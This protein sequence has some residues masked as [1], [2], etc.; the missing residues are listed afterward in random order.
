M[1]LR[2]VQ[3]QLSTPWQQN[4]VRRKNYGGTLAVFWHSL[5]AMIW[6]LLDL[7]TPKRTR[8]HA[9][10]TCN[11]AQDEW[12]ALGKWH[13]QLNI[14][15]SISQGRLAG[16]LYCHAAYSTHFK[17]FITYLIDC[18]FSPDEAAQYVMEGRWDKDERLKH[19][20][21]LNWVTKTKWYSSLWHDGDSCS[22]SPGTQLRC[23]GQEP[24]REQR[25]SPQEANSELWRAKSLWKNLS[26]FIHC[27]TKDEADNLGT[28]I[29]HQP[30]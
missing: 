30:L 28:T 5:F 19:C 29:K 20:P 3:L 18:H 1:H 10:L 14:I 15:K 16:Q 27:R 24:K 8:V 17:V 4:R 6:P 22:T 2:N 9:D 23:S 7:S 25:K 21:S 11:P 26:V 12:A 13:L